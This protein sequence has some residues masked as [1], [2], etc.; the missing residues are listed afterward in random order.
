M[1][2]FRRCGVFNFFFIFFF[3]ILFVGFSYAQI[4]EGI[5]CHECGMKVDPSSKF[6]SYIETIDGKQ[7]FFCDIGDMLSSLNKKKY[8]TKEISVRD[9]KEGGWIDGKSAYY[10]RNQKFVTPMEWGIA[11]FKNLSEAEQWGRPADF[12]NILKLLK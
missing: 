3:A 2:N 9:Y 6:V 7:L 1:L 5:R 4:P 8:E 10:V 11:A 12:D